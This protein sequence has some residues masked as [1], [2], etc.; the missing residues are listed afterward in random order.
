MD[1]GLSA[2]GQ[3]P[4]ARQLSGRGATA[5][6]VGS[7]IGAGLF[8]S[9]GPA[10]AA[11]G[12]LLFVSLAIAALV[13]LCNAASSAQLAAQY[14]TS[15]GTYAFGREQLG[16]WWGFLAG[17]CFLI[18]KTA[19]LAAMALTF[20][21]YA[22]PD[23]RIVAAIGILVVVAAIN[24][25]GIKR[26]ATATAVILAIT[27]VSLAAVLVGGWAGRGPIHQGPVVDGT[28]F[29]VLQGAGL[30]FFAFAGYARLATLGEEVVNPV[31][32]IPRAIITALSFVLALYAGVALTLVTILGTASLA[33]SSHPLADIIDGPVLSGVLTV[34]VS[35]AC[36]GSLLGLMAGVGRTGLAM[37]RAGDLPTGLAAVHPR[38]V[39]H[40]VDLLVFLAA[41]ILVV[42][43]PVEGAIGFSS[44]GVL[45]YYSVTNASAWRQGP[46]WRRY[47][48]FVQGIGFV[49]CLVLA[50]TLPLTSVLPGAAVAAV[51]LI[52][53]F[54]LRARRQ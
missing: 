42:A 8:A 21:H 10:A 40:R 53:R 19:S 29:G 14:P 48:R 31:R 17:W 18:G 45:L 27:L 7:M 24:H 5:I 44:F 47:P 2:A 23:N 33:E 32:T 1:R 25:A 28:V 30:L 36:A 41:L 34:G 43:V 13:A 6:G 38:G 51:G 3:E 16:P 52:L 26:T 49:G 54:A 35:A 4:L 50:C 37:A 39:P 22:A 11:A 20:G 9:F 46:P 15:G 12:S